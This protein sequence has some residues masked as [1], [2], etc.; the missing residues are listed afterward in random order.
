MGEAGH[1]LVGSPLTAVLTLMFLSAFLSEF[2]WAL[3]RIQ[4][5]SARDT[6]ERPREAYHR[7]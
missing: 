4:S 6:S 1:L 7:T 5:L 3:L 2:C